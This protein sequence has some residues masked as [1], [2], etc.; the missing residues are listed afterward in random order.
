MFVQGEAGV[1][2]GTIGA[3][4]IPPSGGTMPLLR[5]EAVPGGVAPTQGAYQEWPWSMTLVACG[6]RPCHLRF[7][8]CLIDDFP[9]GVVDGS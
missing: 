9:A 4:L 5:G 8:S 3:S 2:P 7:D 1:G 6:F